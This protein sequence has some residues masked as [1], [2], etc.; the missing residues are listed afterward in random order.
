MNGQE[1]LAG[2]S[3]ARSVPRRIAIHGVGVLVTV[4]WWTVIVVITV[5]VLA[6]MSTPGRWDARCGELTSSELRNYRFAAIGIS[7]FAVLAPA[8]VG[9]FL[10]RRNMLAWPWFV[11]AALVAVYA[12]AFGLHARPTD[13]CFTF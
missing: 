11:L 6:E 1:A 13:W 5:L 4:L 9:V 12:L 7:F 3:E 8:A 2:A 10:R